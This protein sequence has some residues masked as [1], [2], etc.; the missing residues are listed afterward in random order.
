MDAKFLKLFEKVFSN[1]LRHYK[2]PKNIK[3]L[4]DSS[5]V[6]KVDFE[7]E[8]KE[9]LGR[10]SGPGGQNV[11]KSNNAVVLVHEETR[12][13]VKCH[14][15]RSVEKNREIAKVRLI[16][17]LDLYLN[18]ENCVEAQVKKIEKERE[19]IRK[20]KAR[21]RREAKALKKYNDHSKDI[22]DNESRN[23]CSSTESNDGQN[24]VEKPT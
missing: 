14:E 7:T 6:P 22:E 9:T 3:H 5:K 11:N 18:G 17:K 23:I 10:G 2:V 1:Q 12:V 16:D 24:G 20:E 13:F 15:T 4:V 19:I 21:L 8:V